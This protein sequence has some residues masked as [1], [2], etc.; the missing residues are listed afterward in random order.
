MFLTWDSSLRPTKY[1][2]IFAFLL[3]FCLGFAPQPAE[4]RLKLDLFADKAIYHL[5]EP[6]KMTLIVTNE[7]PQTISAV[8]S[9][10]QSF[11]LA[12]FDQDRKEVWRWSNDKVFAQMLRPFTLPPGKEVRFSAAWKQ[13]DHYGNPVPKG[14]YYIQGWLALSPRKASPQKL[15][16]IN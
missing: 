7:G 16:I 6:V 14:K 1:F 3:F 11:D 4:P 10:S 9:S 5:R 13:A 15:I 8:Y 12:V 2:I